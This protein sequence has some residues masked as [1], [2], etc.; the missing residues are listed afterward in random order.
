MIIYK[1]FLANMTNEQKFQLTGKLCQE[2]LAAVVEGTLPLFHNEKETHSNIKLKAME[3]LV[4]TLT[5]LGS[6]VF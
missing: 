4:D 5:I 1:I 3:L 6:K 2:I